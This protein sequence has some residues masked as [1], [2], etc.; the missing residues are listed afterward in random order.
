MSLRTFLSFHQL[1]DFEGNSGQIPQQTE[2]LSQ[3]CDSMSIESILEIG[4]NA[5]H[6]ADTFLSHSAAHVV[7]F[8][9]NT[10]PCVQKAK[11]YIDRKYPSRHTLV[12]GDST[13][14]IPLY[15]KDHPDKK[16][17]LIYIDGGHSVEIAYAD[18]MNC[19]Q[20]AHEKT[21]VIMDDVVLRSDQQCDWSIGPSKVWAQ[22]ILNGIIQNACGDFYAQGRGM[23][24]G[25]Y[26][27]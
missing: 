14:T 9:L 24:W 19:K 15:T 5:G 26:S 22:A 20:L 17:D 16:F 3:L 13:K 25:H 2:R 10:R 4:F 6:S 27:V 23:G 12:I 1:S 8:D 11:E 21:I 18:L 7:S